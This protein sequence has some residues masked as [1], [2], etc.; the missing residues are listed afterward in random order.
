[1]SSPLSPPFSLRPEELEYGEYAEQL[2]ATCLVNDPWFESKPIYWSAPL[3]IQRDFVARVYREGERIG[4]L[5]EELC[6]V[7]QAEPALLDSFFALPPWYKLMWLSADGWWHGFARM[8]MFLLEDGSLKICE[9]NADTPSGQV[10]MLVPP[11]LLRERYPDLVDVNDT[12]RR[13]FEAMVFRYHR[14]RTGDDSKP[15][16]LGLIY[17]TDLPEDLTLIRLYQRWF[18]EAG[19]EVVLGSPENLG[20]RADGGVTLCGEPVDVVLRHY[21]TDWWGERPRI[22]DDENEVP[23]A[24]PLEREILLLTDA[25]RRGK[26]AVVNPFGALLPQDKLSLAFFF[27]HKAR[28]S[29]AAQR[30]IED[31]L[32]ETRRLDAMDREQLKTERESWVLKSD[33]GCEGDE[34]LVGANVAPDVW[35]HA[36]D[37]ALPGMWVVQRFFDIAP[38]RGPDEREWLPNL[39]VYLVAGRSAGLLVRLAERGITTGHDARVV[40]PFFPP[41]T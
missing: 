6:T 3:E 31:L 24:E 27:E 36:L 20:R 15:E 5:F 34:V 28:F 12:Y 11:T 4:A 33:F 1:V 41:A 21:K 38:L 14:E 9:L 35:E 40:A 25:E 22:F 2:Q 13:A 8:D 16:R 10:E 19:V 18:E 23:D 26:V 37:H 30:T 29:A 7:V 32:P 17:P 39:G